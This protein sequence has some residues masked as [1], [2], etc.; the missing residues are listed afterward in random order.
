M[1]FEYD[2]QKSAKNKVKHGISLEEAKALWSVPAVEIE[3][4]SRIF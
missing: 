4:T 3:A 1:I 2:A